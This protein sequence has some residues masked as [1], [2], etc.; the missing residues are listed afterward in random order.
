MKPALTPAARLARP[1][2]VAP[3]VRLAVQAYLDGGEHVAARVV[4]RASGP[5][6]PPLILVTLW[7]QGTHQP[8]VPGL[9]PRM[10]VVMSS[11]VPPNPFDA[12]VAARPDDVVDHVLAEIERAR[13]PV[14]ANLEHARKP[15]GSFTPNDFVTDRW[16]PGAASAAMLVGGLAVWR[17]I[18]AAERL[19]SP[20]EIF[21]AVDKHFA[22]LG[23]RADVAGALARAF[24]FDAPETTRNVSAVAVQQTLD[25]LAVFTHDVATR[26]AERRTDADRAKRRVENLAAR[27][28]TAK[29]HLDE[30]AR[31]ITQGL[32][33]AVDV[34]KASDDLERLRL[35]HRAA[36][37]AALQAETA[38]AERRNRWSQVTVAG[39][40][41]A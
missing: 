14:I 24:V 15:S 16:A 4:A 18:A 29:A 40:L 10:T 32:K 39:E 26:W 17:E 8:E 35:E 9:N 5:N 20:V 37:G 21:E 3:D 13:E 11:P 33:T 19:L 36:V 22:R 34:T 2:D 6:M 30:A 23:R 25:G 27:V 12:L 38:F 41:S 1:H 7:S 28:Q 31:G